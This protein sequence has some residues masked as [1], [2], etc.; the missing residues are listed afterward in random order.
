LASKSLSQLS[1]VPI[2]DKVISLEILIQF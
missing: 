1:E 2:G